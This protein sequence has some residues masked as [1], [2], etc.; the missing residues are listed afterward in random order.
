[1]AYENYNFVS[2][3]TGTPITGERLAQ[4]S[5]NIEQVKDAT[6]DKPQGILKFKQDSANTSAFSDFSE[7]ELIKLADESGSGGADNRVSVS[8]NRY[9][10]VVLNFP[11]FRIKGKGMEDSTYNLRVYSG[12]FGGAN[13]PI[14][15]WS[16][17]PHT[18][19]F[20]DTATNASTVTTTV[21]STGY[22]TIIGTGTY[23][24]TL[25]SNSSGLSG[26]SF[27]VAV[28]RT[29]G[30]STTNAPDY[31]IRANNSPMQLYIEDA[32]GV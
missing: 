23:V 14:T 10:K 28:D 29:Q 4:M 12:T 27:F 22:D 7:H 19:D 15:T 30:T 24:F 2:W 5:T 32:G 26:E 6:D 11:G 18:F 16:V 20:Y 1:M 8:G 17:T 21:K 3:T 13:T 31:F 9:Y 25:S